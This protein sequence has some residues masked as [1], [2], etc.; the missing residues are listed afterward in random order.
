MRRS[1]LFVLSLL[2]LLAIQGRSLGNIVEAERA[3]G[4]WKTG[5]IR[6]EVA[7]A[8]N[9]AYTDTSTPVNARS[10]LDFIVD[11][12]GYYIIGCRMFEFYEFEPESYF[13]TLLY[14]YLR[15]KDGNLI[16][17]RFEH[18]AAGYLRRYPGFQWWITPALGMWYLPKGKVSLTFEAGGNFIAIDYFYVVPVI[19]LDGSQGIILPISAWEAQGEWSAEAGAVVANGPG[20]SS[21]IHFDVPFSDDYVIYATVWHE[22]E[23]SRRILFE[24]ENGG[25]TELIP[26]SL[27]AEETTSWETVSLGSITLNEGETT[28]KFTSDPDDPDIYVAIEGFIVVPRGGIVRQIPEIRPQMLRYIDG[29]VESWEEWEVTPSVAEDPMGDSSKVT[30]IKAMKAEIKDGFLYVLI[31]YYELERI[32]YS[33]LEVDFEGDGEG[34]LLFL[35]LDPASVRE[36]YRTDLPFEQRPF[37]AADGVSSRTSLVTEIEIPLSLLKDKTRLF[38][39]YRIWSLSE[40]L[41][42]DDT[43]W[44]MV[45]GEREGTGSVAEFN[46]RGIVRNPDGSPARDGL[47]VNVKNL[48]TGVS[49]TCFTGIIGDGWYSATFEAPIEG[50]A[51]SV[52][53]RIEVSVLDEDNKAYGKSQY[54]LTCVNIEI[55]KA[56]LEVRM[57][58]WKWGDVSLNGILS[59]FDASLILR[60][61]AGLIQLS[62]QQL[63]I[64]DVSGD[65]GITARDAGLI[66]MKIVGLIE[67][68]P[69]EGLLQEAPEPARF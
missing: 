34:E 27:S 43:D 50:N 6:H 48:T 19:E 3:T 35:L 45:S 15:D 65:N 24:I 8:V 60:H 68:F 46:V 54:L 28:I 16:P 25:E 33:E 39:R 7:T 41:L 31:E 21:W 64:A 4:E 61:I 32:P 53:D 12:S 13:S 44:G 57:I 1:I 2:G 62:E 37:R 42:V 18:S 22:P 11:T 40:D 38:I 10:S 5:L 47:T 14:V 30:D 26:V 59:A 36:I 55:A 51:A 9:V 20:I 29:R 23:T 17:N 49:L 52:G 56:I 63:E 66:L 67:R 69:A 58:A